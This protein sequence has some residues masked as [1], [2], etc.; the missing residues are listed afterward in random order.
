M[1]CREEGSFFRGH[2]M[3]QRLL[4]RPGRAL[5][6]KDPGKAGRGYGSEWVDL[7]EDC[8]R[9]GSILGG[10]G[11]GPG[12]PEPLACCKQDPSVKPNK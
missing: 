7:G 1:S 3:C 5:F 10:G 11:L 4:P 2:D 9:V 6:W 8:S 12:D